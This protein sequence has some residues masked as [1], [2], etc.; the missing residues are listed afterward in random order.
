MKLTALVFEVSGSVDISLIDWNVYFNIKVRLL[1]STVR[2]ARQWLPVPRNV[3]VPVEW[4]T[5]EVPAWRNF[6]QFSQTMSL[7]CKK[8]ASL[9]VLFLTTGCVHMCVKFPIHFFTRLISNK[10]SIKWEW[11]LKPK[12]ERKL[13]FLSHD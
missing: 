5:V 8:L 6:L 4:W 7:K 9:S 13:S 10:S 12:K 11:I 2:D 3:V 1:S